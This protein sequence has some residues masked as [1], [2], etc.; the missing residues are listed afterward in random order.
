MLAPAALEISKWKK[1]PVWYLWQKAALRSADCIHATAASEYEEIRAL[2][3]IN[4]VAVIP[5]GIDL[6]ILP[7]RPKRER[8]FGHRTILSLGRIHPKKALDMLVRAWATLEMDFPDWRVRIIGPAE[9]GYRE[10]LL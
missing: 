7:E 10:E 4:P 2:G 8:G 6:Q 5:N 9:G 1:R 3:L